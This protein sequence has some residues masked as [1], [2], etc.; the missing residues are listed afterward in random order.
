MIIVCAVTGSTF[1][2]MIT[3]FKLL[4]KIDPS[5][6]PHCVIRIDASAKPAETKVQVLCIAKIGLS[7]VDITEVDVVLDERYH[8]GSYGILD[9]QTIEAIEYGVRMDAFITDPVYKGKSL[10]GMIDMIRKG[11]IKGGNVLYMHLGGQLA[12]NAYSDMENKVG[13]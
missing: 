7:E 3:G 4:A 2:G 1:V 13:A 10:A 12:L 8:A 5:S 6:P 9:K 11:E